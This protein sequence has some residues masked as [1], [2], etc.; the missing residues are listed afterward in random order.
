MSDG[1]A[2]V[3]RLAVFIEGADEQVIQA[4]IVLHL[5]DVMHCFPALE[6]ASK[7]PLADELVL[8][9]PPPA[10]IAGVF[11]D[12][13]DNIPASIAGCFSIRPV[14]YRLVR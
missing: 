14:S 10:M 1:E 2:Q 7:M 12:K 3:V 9:D 4:I 5:V 13:N 11:R 6:Q 8:V